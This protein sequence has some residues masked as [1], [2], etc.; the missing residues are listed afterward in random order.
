MSWL[1]DLDREF[2]YLCPE[3]SKLSVYLLKQHGY[4]Y[5]Q[6]QKCLHCGTMAKYEGFNPI[7]LRMRSRVAFEHNGVKGYMTTDGRG[8]VRYTA[9]SKEH[10]LETGDIKPAYTEG[11]QEHLKK[12]GRGDLLKEV[13][14]EEIIEAREK[15]KELSKLATPVVAIPE[16]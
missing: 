2:R 6:P 13:K 7:K 16:D 3:C 4:D 8:D 5:R 11:Y 10:Y 12:S 9:A 14:R 15:N 1:A